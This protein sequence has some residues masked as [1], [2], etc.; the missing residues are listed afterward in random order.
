MM[1]QCNVVSGAP[2][3]RLTTKQKYTHAIIQIVTYMS[4]P[5]F[6]LWYLPTMREKRGEARLN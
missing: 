6:S 1:R 2:R 5:I 3:T 4:L